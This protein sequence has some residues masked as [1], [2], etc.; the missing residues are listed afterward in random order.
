M[1]TCL[2]FFSIVTIPFGIGVGLMLSVLPISTAIMM[3]LSIIFAMSSLTYS[4]V[5]AEENNFNID[6]TIIATF[7]ATSGVTYIISKAISQPELS[8]IC[9]LLAIIF[10]IFILK[11]LVQDYYR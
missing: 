6:T 2:Y 10:A 7:Y 11:S 1:S 4:Y 8:F 5:N 3:V 9:G